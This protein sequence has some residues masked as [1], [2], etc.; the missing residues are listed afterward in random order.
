MSNY[1]KIIFDIQ[2]SVNDYREI[3]ADILDGSISGIFKTKDYEN[4]HKLIKF[5]A[6][7]LILN[8][9]EFKKLT[10]EKDELIMLIDQVVNFTHALITTLTILLSINDSLDL[11]SK[12]SD[13]SMSKYLKDLEL[14]NESKKRKD[15]IGDFFSASC[16]LYIN[17]L[18]DLDFIL[19]NS[20]SEYISNEDLQK[21]INDLDDYFKKLQKELPKYR[22][23]NIS[24]IVVEINK[25]LSSRFSS[26]VKLSTQQV[27]IKYAYLQELISNPN[28]QDFDSDEYHALQ[29]FSLL[30]YVHIADNS[31]YRSKYRS[32]ISDFVK[33]NIKI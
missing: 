31:A 11:K 25:D 19:S 33:E 18:N 4:N 2:K 29:I 28:Y 22:L 24:S 1:V 6:H 10:S 20:E 17:L 3:E 13:Y 26:L 8:H 27:K 14:Y 9:D 30:I 23:K 15:E 32:T 21:R 16:N 5:L 12:G 7:A